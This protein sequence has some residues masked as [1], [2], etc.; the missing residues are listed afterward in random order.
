MGAKNS[1]T[2]VHSKN[3]REE[4]EDPL[5]TEIQRWCQGKMTPTKLLLFSIDFAVQ[6]LYPALVWHK[7]PHQPTSLFHETPLHSQSLSSFPKLIPFW[8]LLPFQ[9]PKTTTKVKR[10]LQEHSRKIIQ[11]S[12]TQSKKLK[13]ENQKYLLLYMYFIR[14]WIKVRKG[15][16]ISG[17]IKIR[18]RIKKWDGLNQH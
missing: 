8:A 6:D 11:T 12:A 9:V 5:S 10:P 2:T 1:C 4:E 14:I 17:R 7:T 3:Q 15:I 13:K 16:K 18:G